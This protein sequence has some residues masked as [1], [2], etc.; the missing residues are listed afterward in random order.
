MFSSIRIERYRGFENLEMTGL[1]RV[2]LLVGSNNS[3]KTSI[4]EAI[5]LLDAMGDPSAI[6]KLLSRRGEW[7]A[8]A[9]G[10]ASER[11]PA[12]IALEVDA[13]RLFWGHDPFR[14][15]S[16]NNSNRYLECVLD[17]EVHPNGW[18]LALRFSGDPQPI[19]TLLPLSR[20]G[21]LSGES[22]SIRQRRNEGRP[23][24]FISPDSFSASEL[25]AMWNNI[26]L[27][28]TEGLVLEALQ[29]LDPDIERIAIQVPG[30]HMGQSRGGFIVKL[31]GQQRP[32]PIGSLGDGVWRMLAMAM[33]ITQCQGGVLLV[34]EIDSGLHY[35][36]MAKMWGLIVNTAKM[37]DVQVFAT[38]HS[39]D[40]VYSLAQA[41]EP[42]ESVTVQRIESGKRLA[43]PYDQS[44][45]AAAASRG[46]EI[47]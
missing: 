44:E 23:F 7:L 36:V 13:G 15:S 27:T 41:C 20:D 30:F 6:W 34:D 25:G 24:Q 17:D 39:H 8:P 21:G 9:M 11:A 47:R 33:A 46:I 18:Q 12:S 32:V 35:S 29:F 28:P 1:G 38:T 31:R 19:V 16:T 22:S 5:Y 2:N 40:C 43:I 45:L 4:L 14:I 42:G 3:G 37:L 26:T 10:T